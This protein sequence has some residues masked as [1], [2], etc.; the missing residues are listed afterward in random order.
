MR[1]AANN[2]LALH[3][4]DPVTAAKFYCDVLG[5]RVIDPNP[6]CYALE[7]GALR[8]YLVPD[9]APRHEQA[10]PSFDVSDREAALEELQAHG[11]SLVPIGPHAPGGFYVRDPYGV[12]FDLIER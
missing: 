11:C 3:V 10:V 5:C 7:S 6:D 1:F 4:S 9:P 8:I 2:E 12:L